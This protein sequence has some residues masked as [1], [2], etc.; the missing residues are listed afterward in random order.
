M[1]LRP[2]TLATA[3]E[4]VNR[5]H[6]HHKAAVGHK[7]SIGV[8]DD[9]ENLIGVVIVGRPVARN[10]DNGW[11]AEVARL[12]TDGSRNA[13]SILYAAAARA[14][15]AMGYTK[16]QTFILEDECGTSLKAS[17]WTFDG[18]TSGGAWNGLASG[19]PRRNDFPLC[20]K[21]RW[22]KSL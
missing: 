15:A 9:T 11:T 16:I 20:R 1:K 12:C 19:K 3:N 6:R 2:I 18:V 7:F 21:Q 13:C 14:S 5:L 17:G 8:E 22:V 10:S 4:F